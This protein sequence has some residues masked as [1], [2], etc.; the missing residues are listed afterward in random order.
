MLVDAVKDCSMDGPVVTI[1]VHPTEP[2]GQCV[3]DARDVRGLEKDFVGCA[4]S[5]EVAGHSA[6]GDASTPLLVDMG[7]GGGVVDE[8]LDHPTSEMGFEGVESKDQCLKLPRVVA[9]VCLVPKP[10]SPSSKGE[11]DVGNREGATPSEV[12]GIRCDDGRG[13]RRDDLATIPAGELSSPPLQVLACLVRDW[14]RSIPIVPGGEAP[15]LRQEECPSV[16]ASQRDRHC[17]EVCLSEES[18][19]LTRGGHP[20]LE[21][22]SCLRSQLPDLLR[23]ESNRHFV[24]IQ[25]NS[26]ECLDPR[27]NQLGFLVVDDESEVLQSVEEQCLVGKEEVLGGGHEED[28]VEVDDQTKALKTE[29]LSDWSQHLRKKSWCRRESERHC[30]ESP[31]HSVPEKPEEIAIAFADGQME[32]GRFDVDGKHPVVPAKKGECRPDRFHLEMQ[33]WDPLVELS[34]VEDR[35]LAP[36]LLVDAEEARVVDEG[37][38]PRGGGDPFDCTGRF[39]LEDL[40]G[41][42]GTISMNDGRE[43]RR[44]KEISPLDFDW[45]S[46]TDNVLDPIACLQLCPGPCKLLQATP[47]L[48]RW[49]LSILP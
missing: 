28:V 30:L 7:D 34:K 45:N 41:D 20:T 10:E 29:V 2:I 33:D 32:V 12:G 43:R 3:L 49:S 1:P 14:S 40:L 44:A 36:V 35:S 48:W 5:Q 26:E 17:S 19:Q 6:E 4:P 22:R 23:R 11:T 24:C 42:G 21:E 13:R 38:V 37:P 15:V 47:H 39:Q 9:P 27:W 16:E 46:Q 18:C 25:R 8:C 31:V